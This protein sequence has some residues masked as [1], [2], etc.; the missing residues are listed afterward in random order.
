MKICPT[1]IS[2]IHSNCEKRIIL[3]MI[4]NE[5][6]PGW[7]YL[8]IKKLPGLLRGITSK[9]NDNFYYLNCRH[10]FRRENKLEYNKKVYKNKD[11]CEI[12]LP[13]QKYNIL[14]FNQY[15]KSDKTSCVTYA[16]LACLIKEIDNC[17]NIPEKSSIAK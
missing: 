5:E 6:K 17:K 8:A 10:S 9:N 11:F 14:K 12:T 16:D 13:T 7:H 1:Y 15:M 4:P 2:K 3:L